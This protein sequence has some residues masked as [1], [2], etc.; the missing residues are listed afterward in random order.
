MP[1]VVTLIVEKLVDHCQGKPEPTVPSL[2]AIQPP[3]RTH[4]RPLPDDHLGLVPP[5]VPLH[6]RP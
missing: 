1:P 2:V 5:A 3:Y 6:S 4:L